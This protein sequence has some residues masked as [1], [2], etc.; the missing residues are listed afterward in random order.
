MAVATDVTE[1]FRLQREILEISDRE[2]A[3]IGQDVHDGLCQ[4][5][6]GVAFNANSLEQTLTGQQRPEAPPPARFPRCWTKPSPNRDASAAGCT[7]SVSAPRDWC[8]P[9]RNWRPPPASVIRC[10]ARPT[11]GRRL[12]CDVTTATHLYR[13]A[14]EALN[15]AVKHSGAR[16]IRSGSGVRTGFS[17]R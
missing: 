9:W 4:Q 17:C 8:P 7:R 5:L 16:N 3:R 6:I 2:Q 13:I 1:R 10:A 14:Q 11:P 15:N 12:G